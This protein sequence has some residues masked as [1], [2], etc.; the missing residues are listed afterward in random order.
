MIVNRNIYNFRSFFRQ[1][2]ASFTPAVGSL[3]TF[4]LEIMKPRYAFYVK[5]NSWYVE[6]L[7]NIC[8][9]TFHTGISAIFGNYW[10]NFCLVHSRRWLSGRIFAWNRGRQIFVFRMTQK[11]V[12]VLKYDENFCRK[13]PKIAKFA[14]NLWY[15][16]KFLKNWDLN[17]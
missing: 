5:H 1:I 12:P 15:Q 4:L 9:I 14:V 11:I 2:F 10:V 8:I 3:T 6:I 16:G 17:E 7:N 13:L